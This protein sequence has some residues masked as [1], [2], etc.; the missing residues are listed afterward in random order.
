MQR[1]TCGGRSTA[2]ALATPVARTA[3]DVHRY[4]AISASNAATI[5]VRS[6]S[7]LSHGMSLV[8]AAVAPLLR[9]TCDLSRLFSSCRPAV[10]AFF[11]CTSC[12]SDAR[13]CSALSSFSC[14]LCTRAMCLLASACAS[15]ACSFVAASSVRSASYRARS[16]DSRSDDCL[17]VW[18]MSSICCCF[19]ADS[20]AVRRATLSRRDDSVADHCDWA[21]CSAVE[22]RVVSVV[23]CARMRSISS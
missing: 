5:L 10:C 23:C 4:F 14:A 20:S 12:F 3:C 8:V 17:F 9:F 7:T 13:S 19:T 1:E 6:R 21:V 11:S 22:L 2:A 18:N 16:I 15:A